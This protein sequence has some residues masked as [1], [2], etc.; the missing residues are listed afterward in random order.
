M[1]GGSTSE[2]ARL[3]N[4]AIELALKLRDPVLWCRAASFFLYEFA[5]FDKSDLDE[6]AGLIMKVYDRLSPP[7]K[8]SADDIPALIQRARD[9][10][11]VSEMLEKL[12]SFRNGF[13]SYPVDSET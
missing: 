6:T 7:I 3:Y 8:A 5:R 10:P 1:R 13:L 12:T 11:N 4:Q 2:G 9:V